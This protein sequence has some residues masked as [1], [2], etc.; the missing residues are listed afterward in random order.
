MSN[1]SKSL[2]KI[3]TFHLTKI[4]SNKVSLIPYNLTI[5]PLLIFEK[6]FSSYGIH[7]KRELS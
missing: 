5:L 7:I 4:L 6:P 1:R 3:Y 2:P